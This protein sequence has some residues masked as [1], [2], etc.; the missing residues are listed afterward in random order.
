MSTVLALISHLLANYKLNDVIAWHIW[1]RDDVLAQLNHM[2][3]ELTSDQINLILTR[4]NQNHQCDVGHT[5]QTM[6]AE[7]ERILQEE[8][9]HA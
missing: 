1:T 7:I 6:Q 3:A 5:W 8:N 2:D 9:S 4:M